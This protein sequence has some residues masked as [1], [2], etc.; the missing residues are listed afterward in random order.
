MKKS[1]R[2]S[3]KERATSITKSKK[4][5]KRATLLPSNLLF[6]QNGSHGRGLL[7]R[8]PRRHGAR[9]ES[10]DARR[11]KKSGRRSL[12]PKEK[13]CCCA[14][15]SIVFPLTSASSPLSPSSSLLSFS[16]SL[17]LKNS[18]PRRP[19]GLLREAP[20]DLFLGQAGQGKVKSVEETMR[21]ERKSISRFSGAQ[22]S[23]PLST[24]RRRQ[25]HLFAP[26]SP[27]KPTR[28][29]TSPARPSRSSPSSPATRAPSGPLPGPT[30]ASAAASWP[31]PRST[32]ECFSGSRAA[33]AAEEPLP[34]GSACPLSLRR[35]PRP[36]TP[37][38][39]PRRSWAWPWRQPAPTG[40]SPS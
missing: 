38:R 12:E 4:E 31:R 23:T 19:A 29:S 18:G 6:I 40:A 10:D 24:S 1:R 36:S 17:S 2:R 9:T 20:R 16:I 28:S 11:V 22:F 32:T 35:T 13:G 37:W 15:R 25:Q 33:A 8:G 39:S 7:R 30:R 3:P 5:K 27:P 21:N 34:R 26:P 14:H